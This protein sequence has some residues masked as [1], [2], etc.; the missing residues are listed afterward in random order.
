ML[1]HLKLYL[2]HF[3]PAN[4]PQVV[5]ALLDAGCEA[6]RAA[7]M[8]SKLDAKVLAQHDTFCARLVEAC[9]TRKQ[10]SL[11][12]PWLEARLAEGLPEGGGNAEVVQ[13]ALERIDKAA[14]AWW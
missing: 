13:S 14:K 2:Q 10:L 1:G 4:A 12:R 7:E 5:G 3:N 8:L 11:L 6:G 9:E